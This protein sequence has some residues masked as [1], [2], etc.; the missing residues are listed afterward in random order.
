MNEIYLLICIGGMIF[1]LVG[2]A[3]CLFMSVFYDARQR[4]EN[5][6]NRSK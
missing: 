5:H 4:L 6:K 3:F 1:G 2:C